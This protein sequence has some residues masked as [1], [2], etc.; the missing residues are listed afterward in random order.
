MKRNNTI[1]FLRVSLCPCLIAL[2]ALSLS[3]CK[4]SL[5]D[6][7]EKESKEFT[8]KYCPTPVINNERTDSMTFDRD[9]KT[10]T[11][12]RTW[13]DKADNADVINANKNKIHDLLLQAVKN[14]P[15]LKAYKEDG[16][17][18]HFIFRSERS[19][20]TLYE[21]TIGPKQY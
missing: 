5:E 12:Y 1:S 21:T 2:A 11:Y 9:S 4:E 19:K 16:F 7:A 14:N 8:Q 3:S 18:F 17:S 15:S 20:K 13:T 6:K 10:Y